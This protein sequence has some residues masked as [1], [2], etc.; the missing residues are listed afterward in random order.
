MSKKIESIRV[1]ALK[2]FSALIDGQMVSIAKGKI[3]EMPA[4]SDWIKAKLAVPAVEEKSKVV[5]TADLP[6]PEKAAKKTK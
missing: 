2:S 4:G 6:K 5:E 1:V 3:I